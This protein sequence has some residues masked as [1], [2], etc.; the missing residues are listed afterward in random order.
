MLED[1]ILVDKN[2]YENLKGQYELNK[3]LIE[4]ID[5]L[6]KRV[7]RLEYNLKQSAL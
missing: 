4:V 5:Q 2:E 6:N 1:K 7:R 3:E